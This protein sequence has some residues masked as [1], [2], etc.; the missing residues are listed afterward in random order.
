MNHQQLTDNERNLETLPSPGGFL[1]AQLPDPVVPSGNMSV[2]VNKGMVPPGGW[3]FVTDKVRLVAG[4]YE[5]LEDMLFKHR[6]RMGQRTDAV[7]Q[8]IDRYYCSQWPSYCQE[9]GPMNPSS[10]SAPMD[11]RVA[12]YASL[13]AAQMPAGGYPLVQQ[14]EAV[15]RAEICAKCPKNRAWKVGC[16]SCTGA[17]AQILVGMRKMRNT[18]LD[19]SLRACEVFGCELQTAVHLPSGAGFQTGEA[20]PNCWKK[21]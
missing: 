16:R 4:T 18:P 5:E 7:K 12:R 14:T 17:T 15:S 10:V 11:K 3:H 20:P 2:T 8:E 6:V 13:L 9:R 21:D 1:V 19:T